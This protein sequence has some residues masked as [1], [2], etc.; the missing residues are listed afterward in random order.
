MAVK[1]KIDV[2]E[3]ADA[4]FRLRQLLKPGD[5]IFYIGRGTGG[6][7]I[8]LYKLETDTAIYLTGYVARALGMKLRPKGGIAIDG[9]DAIYNLGRVLWPEGFGV[10]G[11]HNQTG[12]KLTP[13]TRRQ[14]AL[15]VKCGYQFRG[16]NADPT[17]WDDDGGYALEKHSL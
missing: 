12:R 8:D 11:K 13:K 14:A 10:Q 3:K 6:T 4:I 1:T 9:W 16:R 17:G 2:S 7:R 5:K 15:A